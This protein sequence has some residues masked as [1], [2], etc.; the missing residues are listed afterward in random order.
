MQE[1]PQTRQEQD[2]RQDER[3]RSAGVRP[4]C[5]VVVLAHGLDIVRDAAGRLRRSTR[6]RR[7]GQRGLRR[8]PP[9]LRDSRSRRPRRG[10]ARRP[11]HAAAAAP[12]GPVGA[13][14]MA[15]APGARGAGTLDAR[16]AAAP[17]TVAGSDEMP[18]DESSAADG[19]PDVALDTGRSDGT[20]VTSRPARPSVVSPTARGRLKPSRAVPKA[21]TKRRQPVG[22]RRAASAGVR[23]KSRGRA[24]V[25][26]ARAAAPRATRSACSWAHRLQPATRASAAARSVAVGERS[27]S[28][29]TRIGSCVAWAAVV[30]GSVISLV[31]RDVV[32]TGS[33]GVP[34]R[35]AASAAVSR[36]SRVRCA[37]GSAAAARASDRRSS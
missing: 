33:R 11:R 18:P 20:V 36:K 6:R 17:A 23:T 28:A 10:P 19:P 30:R 35:R 2:A 3:R 32:A 22:R 26:I 16:P 13:S 25:G 5:E 7:L 9:A 15:D 14:T 24:G 29:A 21:A 12:A 4:R 1:Q 27:V 37:V 31:R 34:D 8:R